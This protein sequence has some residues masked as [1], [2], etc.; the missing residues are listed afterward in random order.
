MM[1]F[2]SLAPRKSVQVIMD[3]TTTTRGRERKDAETSL[4]RAKKIEKIN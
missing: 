1:N 4:V 3:S 2:Q